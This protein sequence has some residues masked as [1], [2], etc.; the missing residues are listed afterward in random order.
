MSY[1]YPAPAPTLSG[2]TITVNKY[3][4]SPTLVSRRINEIALNRYIGDVLLSARVDVEG[5]AIQYETRGLAQTNRPIE[6]VT[7]G[8]E[9]PLALVGDQVASIAKVDKRGQDT[10]V[11]DEEIRRSKVNSVE[12]AMQALVNS[13]IVD[14]DGICLSL[15]ASVVTATHGAATAWDSA[16]GATILRDIM[17][18]KAKV[19]GL[20]MGYSPNT[21]VVSDEVFALVASDEKL[22][23]SMARETAS[24]AVY[25]GN[26]PVV[27]GLRLLPTPNLPSGTEALLVDTNLLGGIGYE[28]L[29]GG[30]TRGQ[31][32]VETKSMREDENDQWRLRARRVATPYVTDPGAAIEITGVTS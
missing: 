7:P 26:F 16:S 9:Y 24:N 18:A 29:G 30:Y 17:L 5:G 12:R 10:I 31:A 14:F 13:N 1:T 4:S 20:N 27:A 6:S 22:I 2:D 11:T 8:G 15:I 25:T 19:T 32:N 28:N 21:L 3:L 23:G